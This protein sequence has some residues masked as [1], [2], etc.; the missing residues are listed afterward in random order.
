MAYQYSI[1]YIYQNFFIHS[2][3]NGHLS[4]FHIYHIRSYNLQRRMY[5]FDLVSLFSSDK[6]PEMK[7]LDH[8]VVLG[9][10]G[11]LS[12]KEY[13]CQCRRHWFTP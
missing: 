3:I 11:W 9:L 4:Y 13:A 6:Y 8:M 2:S 10:P 1:V 12:G 7:L 5:L